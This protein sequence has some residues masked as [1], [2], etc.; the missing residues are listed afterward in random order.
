MDPLPLQILSES[1]SSIPLFKVV[2]PKGGVYSRISII[3]QFFCDFLS[4]ITLR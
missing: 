2:K 4:L 3:K 1:Y